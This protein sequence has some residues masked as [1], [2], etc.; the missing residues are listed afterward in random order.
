MWFFVAN[1]I[2]KKKVEKYKWT[3][4]VKNFIQL[5]V[6]KKFVQEVIKIDDF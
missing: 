4:Y 3:F 5:S 2:I 6:P 1:E